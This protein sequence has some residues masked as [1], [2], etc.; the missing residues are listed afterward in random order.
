MGEPLDIM[1]NLLSIRNNAT[2]NTGCEA[3]KRPY[4]ANV[5]N[6]F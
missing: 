3:I 5:H 6:V 4:P 2:K 1:M